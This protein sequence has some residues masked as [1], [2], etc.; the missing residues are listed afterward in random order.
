MPFFNPLFGLGLFQKN[1]PI[2]LNFLF[3]E[4]EG[5]S[6]VS[7]HTGIQLLFTLYAHGRLRFPALGRAAAMPP[8]N[9]VTIRKQDRAEG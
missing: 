6:G 4:D 8:F 7:G 5:E 9:E 1:R 2:G 3:L